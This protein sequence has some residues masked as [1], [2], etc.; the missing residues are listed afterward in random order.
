[1]W[2]IEWLAIMVA[3]YVV[4]MAALLFAVWV[5]DRRWKYRKAHPFSKD[6]DTDAQDPEQIFP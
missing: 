3:G 4:T 5:L 2:L 6:N 1:M